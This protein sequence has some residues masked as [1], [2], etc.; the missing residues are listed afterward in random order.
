LSAEDRRT[1]LG[2]V[3]SR[4]LRYSWRPSPPPHECLS[5]QLAAAA[6]LLVASGAGSLGWWRVRRS[7]LRDTPAALDLQDAYRL[8]ALEAILH[9]REITEV[10]TFLRG[11]GVEPI[12]VKGWAVARLYPEPGLRPYWDIDLCCRPDQYADAVAALGR[13]E[14]PTYLVDLHR[15]LARLDEVNWDE[16]YARS[17]VV[18]IGDVGVRVLSQEDHLRLLCIHLLR[19]GAWRP[20]WLCDIAAVVETRPADFD[21]DRCLGRNR[22]VADWIACAIGLARRLLKVPVDDTPVATRAKHL[23]RWL[24]PHVLKQWNSP[25]PKLHPPRSYGGPLIFYIRHRRRLLHA[26][27][28]RWPDPI[29]ATITVRGPLNEWPRLPFQIGHY[30]VKTGEF[31]AKLAKLSQTP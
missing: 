8:H 17:Q 13:L 6:P 3:L 26:L 4:I 7:E 15:G 18:M 27:R 5:E 19:H 12:L 9:E 2:C 30:V 16:L 11:A 23:P 22:R 21:W 1:G 31:F 14:H 25:F 28:M 10:L 29:A 20:L 24:V